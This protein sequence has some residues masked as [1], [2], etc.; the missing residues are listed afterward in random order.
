[1]TQRQLASGVGVSRQTVYYIETG[2]AVPSVVLALRIATTF[3]Q[4]AENVFFIEEDR[5]KRGGR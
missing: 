4:P 2:N 3:Q 5:R 1:M